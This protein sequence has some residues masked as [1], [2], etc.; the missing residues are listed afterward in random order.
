MTSPSLDRLIAQ[1]LSK[2]LA[3]FLSLRLD[4]L[5]LAQRLRKVADRLES[6]AEPKPSTAPEEAAREEAW[7][8][9][10]AH[11][12]SALGKAQAKPTAG[13]KRKVLAR[14]RA[15]YSEAEI[16]RAIDALSRSDFHLGHNDRGQRYD[17][18]DLI[19]RTDE[20]LE[21]WIALAGEQG[22]ED[23][24]RARLR[25]E[26]ARALKEGDIDAYHRANEKLE[27]G[28]GRER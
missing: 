18:L 3:D 27:A 12:R 1:T 14:L 23:L 6:R 4:R 24:P 5:A 19:C 20:K 9:I 22:I 21:K 10:F 11:W 25:R 13:R 15:G 8:R 26:A 17:D 2:A 28:A 7:R 16:L